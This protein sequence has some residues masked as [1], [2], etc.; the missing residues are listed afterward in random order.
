MN[1]VTKCAGLFWVALLA[2]AAGCGGGEGADGTT[3]CAAGTD[4]C[5]CFGNG[6]CLDSLEC[7][8]EIC[9]VAETC[10]DGA[11]GCHCVNGVDCN[12]GLVCQDDLCR[13]EASGC[14]PGGEGCACTADQQCGISPLG[15]PL[16]CKEDI[17]SA[18]GCPAGTVGCA[19]KGGSICPTGATCS[20]GFCR[21]LDCV[22]GELGCSCAGGSC[23]PGL[24]CH[25]AALCIDATGLL[26]GPCF[27]AG[28]CSEGL[29]CQ[30]DSCVPCSLGSKDCACKAGGGCG[31]AL[32]C[33]DGRCQDKAD[34]GD[35]PPDAPACYTPCSSDLVLDDGTFK[36]C[37]PDGLMSGCLGNLTCVDGTC[38]VAGQAKPTCQDDADCPVFQNCIYGKCYSNCANDAECSDGRICYKHVCRQTCELSGEACG[39][40][41]SCIS[42]DGVLGVC[43]AVAPPGETTHT[44]VEGSFSLSTNGIQLSNVDTSA[45]FT[46]I[47]NSPSMETFIVHKRSHK[48]Y[49]DDGTSKEDDDPWNDGVDCDPALNCPLYWLTMGPLSEVKAQQ[50]LTVNVEG[51]GGEVKI[52]LEKAG[53]GPGPKWDGRVEVAHPKL[54]AQTVF[55]AYAE[56]PEGRWGG[57]I[58]YFANFGDKELGAWAATPESKKSQTLVDK[59]NNALI[60]RWFAFR[61]GNISWEE[62][63]AVTIATRTESWRWPSVQA[64]CPEKK[65]ACY[66]Y[67]INDLG[68][69]VY[70][71]D[72]ATKPVPSGVVEMPFSMDLYAPDP[73]SE[74]T[75]LAGRIVSD[76][77]LQYP[78]D[79]AIT[80]T[81]GADPSTC[82]KKTGGVCLVYVDDLQAQVNLGGRY[83]SDSS[84]STCASTDGGYELTK[85][86]WIIPGFERATELDADT[87]QRYR[88]E[89]RDSLLPMNLGPGVEIPTQTLAANMA[90]AAASPI[91]DGKSR[92]RSFEVLDGA[93]VNQ[94]HLFLIFRETYKSFLPGD[95]GD[96]SAY[97]FMLLARQAADLD[98]EDANGNTIPDTFEGSVPWDDRT[99]PE[100][101]LDL[102]CSPDLIETVLGYGNR[103]VTDA[104]AASLAVGLIDGTVPAAGQPQTLAPGGEEGVH[105]LCLANGL[106]DGGSGAVTNPWL[107]LENDNSCGKAAWKDPKDPDNESKWSPYG[108]N[109]SCDDGGPGSDTAICPI[110]T[111]QKD[112]GTRTA[113]DGDFRRACPPG[114]NVIFFTVDSAAMS[115]AAVAGLDCQD[116]GSCEQQLNDWLAAGRPIVQYK[117]IWR[118]T[119]PAAVY[120]DGNRL[121]LRDGK[122]F[123]AASEQKAVLTPLY[124]AIDLAFRYKTQFRGRDG[125]NLGFAPQTCLPD[126]NQ[127]PY[128]YDPAEIEAAQARVD[129]LL[130]LWRAHFEAVATGG[131]AV[132][133][134]LQEYLCTNF[135]YAEACHSGMPATAVPHDGFERLYSELLV[136]MG[137]ES[138]TRA[139]ASRF[140]LAG[141]GGSTFEGTL[142]ETGGINLSGASGMEMLYLYQAAEYY[143]E[144]LDRFYSLSPQFWEAL[145][146]GK[147]IGKE[148]RN[149]VTQATVTWYLERLTRAATQKSRAW[150]EIAKRYQNLNRPDLARTVARRAYIATYVESI[151]LSQLMLRV[152]DTL[153]PQDRPQVALVLDQAQKRYRM[154]MLDMRN[155]YAAIADEVNYFGFRPDYMPFP[156]LNQYEDNGFEVIRKRVAQKVDMAKYREDLAINR[157][158]AFETDA[159]A[160]Q[161]E[162]LTLRM[163]YEAQLGEICG[164]FQGPDGRIYPAIE[165]YAYLSDS[166][167]S[168][169]DPCGQVGNGTIHEARVGYEQATLDMKKIVVAEQTILDEVSIEKSRVQAQCQLIL[170]LADFVYT[171]G[172][173]AENLQNAINWMHY[174]VGTLDRLLGVFST[175]LGF[176]A[177]GLGGAIAGT[178]YMSAAIPANLVAIGMEAAVTSLQHDIGQINL[179]TA[180]WQTEVQCDQ[181]VVDSNARTASLLLQTRQLQ[182]DALRA[183]HQV[184]LMLSEIQQQ[185]NKAKRLEQ[186]LSESQQL[187]INVASARNDPNVRIYRNDAIVNAD[188]SFEDAIREVYRLTLMY[189]YYT[190]TSYAARDKLFL[191]R[192]VQFGDYNLENYIV[193]L[194]NTYWEF[195]DNYG[196]PDMRVAIISLRDDIF[197]IPDLDDSGKALSQSDRINLMRK[198]LTDPVLLDEN[199]YIRIPFATTIDQLC[200]LTR[201]HKLRYLEAEVIGS[202]VGDTL[203]RLYVRQAGT[204]IVRGL[205]DQKLYYR[206]P[207]KTAVVNPFFNGN[208]VFTPELYQ[209]VRLRER[210]FANTAWE[211]YINQRD[212]LEN[213]DIDL[214]SLTD[215]RIYVYY[216][217]FTPF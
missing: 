107:N 113:S 67:D 121:D 100:G 201:I 205:D 170:N 137:D 191:V 167:R 174:S 17:C 66:P 124:A 48:S 194:E 36:S 162:L 97:G 96:F 50:E 30:G 69:V 31:G 44:A 93:L 42:D 32:V 164:T 125:T 129:C 9:Q 202:D 130:H 10:Q 14:I 206:F 122:T 77:A 133:K 5:A 177:Q 190:G 135:S 25:D 199:G 101:L 165:S 80:V 114:S 51:Q 54:G 91:P 71:S 70:S 83:V 134:K 139:M 120:C 40:G 88:F 18:V 6:S 187:A 99:E 142:F 204:G 186:E 150:S 64:A 168:L 23:G 172:T 123:F 211:L 105:Y 74:P 160:F 108:G 176:A 106:F 111:D 203:G 24:S 216:R 79:P 210:P 184:Q 119:D 154:A 155:A 200:P 145:V 68:I 148:E 76:L 175:T 116:D 92:R 3:E 198:R 61:T 143:Q 207:E 212:E 104:N 146:Y 185:F 22:P 94:T 59:V 193:D 157:N 21:S 33:W 27:E 208:R 13:E 158:T 126:S 163:N 159:E 128:C 63:L 179:D 166:T 192:M 112:C 103:T 47:N 181:A 39:A 87:G 52:Y 188:I 12:E 138:Y 56:R 144:A 26:G 180:K 2:L 118:C 19:C 152:T 78:G 53:D 197:R 37:P 171:Q 49:L 140:D 82:Q 85:V 132:K 20:G 58:Y 35:L 189:E 161:S 153:K 16:E 149:F 115:Q 81:L 196:W 98:M 173:K 89:C 214:N 209:S 43:L 57:N 95:Q 178:A 102:Q 141:L 169:G 72:T 73:A 151:L 45:S 55:L 65:G 8:E 136:M 84:D 62:F 215:V 90:L 110:G 156:T 147:T 11:L 15:G 182:L 75:K 28:F 46:I 183:T 4:G 29:R 60:Q 7:R 86:P 109:D 38:L 195:E 1:T 127:V 41:Q 213:Q 131:A 217:D 34:L 117:P